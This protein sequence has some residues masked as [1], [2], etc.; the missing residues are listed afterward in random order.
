MLTID[1][2]RALIPDGE[3][4]S[5]EEIA[6]IRKDHYEMIQLAFDVWVLQRKN[7]KHEPRIEK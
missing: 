2:C 4:L 3:E 7:K 1:E 6:Q 5:N